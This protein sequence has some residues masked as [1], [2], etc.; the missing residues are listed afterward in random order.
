M[1]RGSWKTVA[2]AAVAL[3]VLA[4]YYWFAAIPMQRAYIRW[5]LSGD[6]PGACTASEVKP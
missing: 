2:M 4:L 3:V 5:L 6:Q 1:K